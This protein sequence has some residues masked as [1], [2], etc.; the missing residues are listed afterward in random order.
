[1]SE[2]SEYIEAFFKALLDWIP[3]KIIQFLYWNHPIQVIVVEQDCWWSIGSYQHEPAVQLDAKIML[4]N[5]TNKPIEII[6]FSPIDKRIIKNIHFMI[7][8][9][10]GNQ[11]IDPVI[12]PNTTEEIRA[13]CFF[14]PV[15][16]ADDSQVLGLK[17]V[18]KNSLGR[19]NNISIKFKS[20]RNR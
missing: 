17:T 3:D 5:R 1:M 10:K 20:R 4:T 12:P 11:G 14:Q 7:L 16:I 15:I 18:I 6:G 19:N 13:L 2:I 8:V 9:I